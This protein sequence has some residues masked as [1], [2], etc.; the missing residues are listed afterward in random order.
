M[1]SKTKIE[2]ADYISNPIKI[3][4]GD[5]LYI[6]QGDNLELYQVEPDVIHVEKP[7]KNE[8]HPTMKPLKLMRRMI[9]NSSMQGD[10]V[11]D[12][13]CGSGSTLLACENEKRKCLA[14]E[15]LPKY[16][17][18]TLQRWT[19]ATGKEPRLMT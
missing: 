5:E 11:Y 4:I 1:P 13:F 8:L 2:W 7:Q 18:V 16:A 10:I 9:R 19:D 3:T 14:V 6:V 12:P 17:A 15:L